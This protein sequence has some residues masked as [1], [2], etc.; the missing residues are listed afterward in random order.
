MQDCFLQLCLRVAFVTCLQSTCF[1]T[2]NPSPPS[3][4]IPF[5][6]TENGLS[7]AEADQPAVQWS[8]WASQE[9]SDSGGRGPGWHGL[10]CQ[11]PAQ[12]KSPTAFTS[13]QITLLPAGLTG[14]VNTQDPPRLIW[15]TDLLV[16]DLAVIP[17]LSLLRCGDNDSYILSP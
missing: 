16:S 8:S 2:R 7:P 6:S 10:C 1:L 15:I 12:G 13:A 11:H 14:W 17:W 3:T 9:Q 5:L 4:I